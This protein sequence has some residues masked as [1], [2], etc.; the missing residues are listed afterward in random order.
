MNVLIYML[1]GVAIRALLGEYS[2]YGVHLKAFVAQMC[3]AD[4]P[5]CTLTL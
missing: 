2:K 4:D 3:F 1:D 5:D